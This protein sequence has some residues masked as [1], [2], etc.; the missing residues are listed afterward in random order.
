MKNIIVDVKIINKEDG[1][2]YASFK[3]SNGTVVDKE[4]EKDDTQTLLN[5]AQDIVEEYNIEPTELAI[6]K[7]EVI[8]VKT[9]TNKIVDVEE[10]EEN[11]K[12]ISEDKN[13]VTNNNNGKLNKFVDYIKKNNVKIKKAG[14]IALMVAGGFALG[15][16]TFAE[17]EPIVIEETNNDLN[18]DIDKEN[19][20]HSGTSILPTT[21]PKEEIVLEE[22]AVDAIKYITYDE[23]V[24]A[25]D[26]FAIQLQKEGIKNVSA[27]SIN[28]MQFIANIGHFTPET[29]QQL[30]ENNVIAN[31]AK[32]IVAE[33]FELQDVVN[34]N[35]IQGKFIDMSS[36]LFVKE[37]VN[38]VA[39]ASKLVETMYNGDNET[40][41]ESWNNYYAYI[42]NN[43][44]KELVGKD[45][46]TGF[47]IVRSEASHGADYMVG[48]YGVNIGASAGEA[49]VEQYQLEEV[50]EKM[51]NLATIIGMM[52]DCLDDEVLIQPTEG[53]TK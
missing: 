9:A 2:R 12:E 42:N 7:N 29:V 38:T 53:K 6:L 41:K 11:N 16:C 22:T 24:T 28:A 52:T 35:A 40:K 36:L 23:F 25:S 19:S 31:D 43:N 10:I 34:N 14:I 5:L 18:N 37:D 17:K 21:A 15:R 47:P 48:I 51:N 4:Y 8:P 49:S 46:K 33:S 50:S 45:V 3:L 26:D 20:I 13:E 32:I 30:V 44:I 27:R 39:Y 1:K